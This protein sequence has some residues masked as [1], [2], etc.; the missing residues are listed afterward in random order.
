[1]SQT[2]ALSCDCGKVTLTA[3]GEPELS[4]YCH[5]PSCRD[6]YSVDIASLTAWSDDNIEL[7]DESQLFVHKM[8]DREM[9]RYGCA[10]CGMTLFG[11]H[12][13]GM[14]VVPHGVFRKANGGHLPEALA[15][16][17]HLFYGDRV[18]DVD[19]SLQKSQGGE[20]VGL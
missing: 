11:R 13:P 10:E 9:T 20:L 15:P 16:T 18:I 14:P 17:M 3:R 1:M 5:C 8:A 4:L 7:P 6:L 19:D 2:Y 12:K